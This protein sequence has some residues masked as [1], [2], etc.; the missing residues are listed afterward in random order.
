MA[1]N[2]NGD[3]V[4][5]EGYELSLAHPRAQQTVGPEVHRPQRQKFVQIEVT[6]VI[7]P[8]LV[9]LSFDVH[10]QAQQ[11]EQTY[12]GN[13]SLYPPDHPGKFI[14]ATQGKLRAGGTVSV[15]LLPLQQ[16]GSADQVRVRLARIAFRTE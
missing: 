10:F 15:T 4:V 6:Q 7:N 9:P 14:V 16:V 11:G 2:V 8:R 3:E 13:F 5:S 12:L 1:S